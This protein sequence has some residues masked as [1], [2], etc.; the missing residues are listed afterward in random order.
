M[1]CLREAEINMQLRD[2]QEEDVRKLIKLPAAGIFNEQRTGKTPTA[3]VATEQ[4]GVERL[5]IVC[6]SSIVYKW[7]EEYKLWTGKDAD[8]IDSASKFNKDADKTRLQYSCLVINYE[9]LRDNG[10]NK[11]AW[12]K[13][14][15][16][17][18]PDGLIVD[19]AHRVKNR[20]SANFKAVKKFVHSRFRLYLT[21]TPAPN[22]PWDVWAILH[23]I[24][25]DVF[26][27]YWAFVEN[28]FEQETVYFGGNPINM[29]IKFKLGMDTLLQRNLNTISVMRK[30]K[31]VMPWL[32]TIDSPT[33]IKLPCTATQK[34]Y[35]Q[36][37]E[38]NFET[39]HINTQSV[40]EQLIR[41]RQICAA[42]SI[43]KL[44]GGSPKIDWLK[45]YIKDYPNK[46]IIVFSNS[47]R[48]I[49]EIEQ[50]LGSGVIFGVI[51]GATPLRLRRHYVAG[52]QEGTTKLLIIQTQAGKEGLTLDRADVTIFLDTY[53]PAA[54]YSQAKDRMIATI[55]E[56][57]RPQEI[58]H[59]MM[60]DTYDEHLY[61]LVKQ[62]IS[63]TEV[64][65]DYIKYIKER[66]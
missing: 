25:P 40:L 14:V 2:Y 48:F 10:K 7:A 20:Q 26:S 53:P 15:K 34:R 62:G 63:S 32:P 57:V 13:L 19:E 24:R 35:I 38:T 9:N 31:D 27:S 49:H 47:T 61:R 50:S 51:V 4:V 12:E 52:F 37:L 41:I 23:L 22:K 29:P 3:I 42:P 44:K 17:Y 21:G 8:V 6:P 60:K 28:Y 58:I 64:V 30:R 66:S 56:N 45:L 46:S 11:G 55:P 36:E 54:D 18:K 16:K 5:L 39:E 33:E 43:L 59:I 65:N 1:M